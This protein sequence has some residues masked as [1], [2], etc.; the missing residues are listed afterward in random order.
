M[1]LKRI[2]EPIWA[3]HEEADDVRAFLAEHEV[4]HSEKALAQALERLEVAE[5]LAQRESH[6][7]TEYLAAR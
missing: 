7:L 5:M 6:R 2:I 3:R 1:I 4:P